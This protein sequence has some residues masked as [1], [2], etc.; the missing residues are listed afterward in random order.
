MLGSMVWQQRLVASGPGGSPRCPG[1]DWIGPDER[2][3]IIHLFSA[4]SID[5]YH[6]SVLHPPEV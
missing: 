5:V 2:V 6:P 4:A 3:D 1:K